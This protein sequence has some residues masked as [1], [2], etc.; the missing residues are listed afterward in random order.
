MSNQV[1]IQTTIFQNHPNGGQTKGFRIYDGYGQAY[2]NTW[3]S[4]PDDDLEIL[5]QVLESDDQTVVEM[6]DFL[7]EHDKGICINNEHYAWDRIKHLWD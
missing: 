5:A 7:M 6:L 3:D 4:I 2:D 1:N